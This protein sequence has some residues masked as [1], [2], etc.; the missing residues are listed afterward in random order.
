M[1]RRILSLLLALTMVLGMMPV[2]ALATDSSEITVVA[3]ETAVSVEYIGTCGG[4]HLQEAQDCF[5]AEIP[6][7][8]A[9]TITDT[10]VSGDVVEM[11]AFNGAFTG[12]SEKGGFDFTAEDVAQ[13]QLTDEQKVE[14]S[15][16]FQFLENGSWALLGFTDVGSDETEYVFLKILDSSVNDQKFTVTLTEGGLYEIYPYEDSVSPVPYGSSFSFSVSPVSG[17][18]LNNAKVSANGVELTPVT[19]GTNYNTYTITN[20]TADQQITVEGVEKIIENQKTITAP[21]GAEV[22]V[23]HQNGYDKATGNGNDKEIEP[24]KTVSNG[25]TVTY[26]YSVPSAGGMYVA[27]YQNKIPYAGYFNAVKDVVL[28]WE[29]E[30]KTP[31]YR[32]DYDTS[33]DFGSYADDSVYTNVNSNGHLVL[34]NEFML[35]AYRGWQIVNTTTNNVMIEP[36]FNY[37]TSNENIT[38][39]PY[40]DREGND[41]TVTASGTS[42]NNWV[43][44]TPNGSGITYLEIGYDAVHIVDGYAA[45][46]TEGAAGQPSNFTW[47]ASDPNRTALL[48]V[49]TDGNAASG[50]TFGIQSP[51]GGWDYEYDTVY[52][53]ESQGSITMKPTGDVATVSVSHNK[54]GSYQTITGNDGTYVVPIVPGNN[55]IRITDSNGRTAFQVVRGAQCSYTVTNLSR[56]GQPVS[57][58]DTVRVQ[59]E[60]MHTVCPKISGVYNPGYM[61]SNKTHYTLNGGTIL[62]SDGYQYDYHNNV[63][64]T[65]TA[66]NAQC[67]L[68]GGTM[69][70][71]PAMG[72]T[73]GALYQANAVNS[74]GTSS[75]DRNIL[76]EISIEIA[77][78]M[79]TPATFV[80]LNQQ[81]VTLAVGGSIMLTAVVEPETTTDPLVWTS[82]DESV[83]TVDK[84]MVKAVAAGE[85][86]ITAT[87]GMVSASCQ[88]VVTNQQAGDFTLKT[89]LA[90]QTP[91]VYEVGLSTIHITGPLPVG[92]ISGKKGPDWSLNVAAGTGDTMTF[93]VTAVAG[94]GLGASKIQNWYFWIQDEKSEN[95][96][97]NYQNYTYTATVTPEWIDNVATVTFGLGPKKSINKE[98]TYTI[99]MTRMAA[100]EEP[101]T[102]TVTL[103][104]KDDRYTI[105]IT[106]GK[107]EETNEGILVA[108]G[109]SIHF[110]VTPAAGY[111]DA[112]FTVKVNGEP[113]EAQDGVYV[114]PKIDKDQ[115]V[116]VDV[117]E[118][119]SQTYTVTMNQGTGYSINKQAGYISTVTSG[120]SFGFAVKVKPSYVKGDSYA[121]LVNGTAIQ[122]QEDGT[123]LIENITE[124]QSIS[125]TG[126]EPCATNS[127]DVYFSVSKDNDF[128]TKNG[129]TMAL[130]KLTV[131]YFDLALYGLEEVYYNPD[132]YAGGSKE[133]QAG[134]TP[135]S[136]NGNITALHLFLYATEVFYNNLPEAQA[137][138]GWLAEDGEWAGYSVNETWPGSVYG[139]FWDFGEYNTYFQNYNYPLGRA[140]WGA[141]CDQILLEDGD[142]ISVRYKNT[143]ELDQG[144]Y[145]HFGETGLLSTTAKQGDKV[146]LT[147]YKADEDYTDGASTTHVV[148]EDSC[149]IYVTANSAPTSH[150]ALTPV[151][152]TTDGQITLD[153][154]NLAPNTTYFVT[155]NTHDPAVMMLIVE[156]ADQPPVQPDE[157]DEPDVTVVYGDLDGNGIVAAKDAA[158]AYAIAKEK[159][160]PTDAQRIAADVDGNGSVAAKDAAMIYAKAKEK[161]Q[162]FPVELN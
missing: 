69:S 92:D 56:E 89:R 88:V 113:V 4:K 105:E 37:S 20:I 158:M 146:S 90:S 78:V 22:H 139:R 117:T 43:Y 140:T 77:G 3:G 120:G 25:D 64:I 151:G 59:L 24:V 95:V 18:H 30:T 54:G 75:Q 80:A 131:P 39:T 23:Y 51:S 1:R 112:E 33:T 144:T 110:T 28:S 41:R 130:Q 143:A 8:T 156:E 111:E 32:G 62:V 123:Y 108:E 133:T 93:T 11:F 84:G 14:M 100:E 72:S 86:T 161:L 118:A 47:N 155:A 138:K 2:T 159:L 127:V 9:V 119:V 149:N 134:G 145:Y 74:S 141:A 124:N 132:C 76:P 142:I 162:A 147:L 85:A 63:W 116:S 61:G 96:A 81:D 160:T 109:E 125:V 19:V 49:Q 60:G 10:N 82:S 101:E 13:A 114:L 45:G 67:V 15:G 135:E 50:I 21:S 102:Y 106:D 58:G 12:K 97:G 31:G 150:A 5:V 40:N 42:S 152:T 115:T 91:E 66:P 104:Q 71:A 53:T 35:R 153:T 99:T 29:G 70:T 52:F 68:T 44:L 128:I 17:Y 87:A 137:G 129:R 122:P 148:V 46:G 126:V 94:G 36:E 98:A 154:S 34:N 6:S 48:V 107:Y 83:A 57:V 157:P 38:I 73:I 55:I 26:T 121:V 65:F 103:P 27:F 16:E 7:G 79:D 136:A